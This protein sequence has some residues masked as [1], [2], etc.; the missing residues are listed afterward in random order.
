MEDTLT[1]AFEQLEAADE[2]GDSEKTVKLFGLFDVPQSANTFITSVWNEGSHHFTS[3]LLPNSEKFY[4]RLGNSVGLTGKPLQHGVAGAVFAT[5]ALIKAGPLVNPVFASLREQHRDRQELARKL[6][7]VLNDITGNHS[8]GALMALKPE[9]NEMIFA[10][11]KRMAAKSTTD[12]VNNLINIGVNVLPGI[13]SDLPSLSRI[14]GGKLRL[15]EPTAGGKDNPISQM[16]GFI[17]RTGASP[18][19][20]ILT[21]SNERNLRK[22]FSSEY[23]ALDMALSL[24]QQVEEDS[25][26]HG[27]Q[28]PGQR[29]EVLSLEEYIMRMMIQH[30]RDMADITHD[31][32]ELRSALREDMEAV[33]KPLAEAISNGDMSALSLVRLIGEGKIIKKKGRAIAAPDEVVGLIQHDKP[34]AQRY[35]TVDAKEYYA[36][37]SFTK[38]E[39]EQALKSLQGEEKHVFAAM[40]PD[41][42]LEEAGMKKE[43]VTQLRE[44]MAQTHDHHL[45]E[46]LLGAASRTD[47]ELQKDGL[48]GNEIRLIREAQQS[49]SEQGEAAMKDLKSGPANPTGIEQAM[50]NLAV[51]RVNGDKQYMGTMLNQGRAAL[52]QLAQTQ[53]QEANAAEAAG[54]QEKVAAQGKGGEAFAERLD[55]AEGADAE[56][57]R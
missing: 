43:E 12:N 23:S 18:L 50:A 13:A 49:L 42:I 36:N 35:V 20:N 7:P 11:R 16:A 17:S 10:H 56:V 4:T 57:T 19:A 2:H 3:W 54:F 22:K 37:A 52:K 55:R 44:Q 5:N 27:F 28:L 9:Q 40:F 51:A 34:K 38:K 32:T 25:K 24:H 26:A 46:A 53:T 33:A 45:A 6:S 14:A 30:Q 8:V 39:L 29:G 1:R 21:R 15:P 31:H 48:A 41:S 47:A